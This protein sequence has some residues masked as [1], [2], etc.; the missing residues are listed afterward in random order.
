MCMKGDVQKLRQ[1]ILKDKMFDING[2][3]DVINLEVV[4][5]LGKFMQVYNSKVRIF[6]ETNSGKMRVKI[7][8]IAECVK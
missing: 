1:V 2:L 5:T 6:N 7:E 3:T 8:I 4:N